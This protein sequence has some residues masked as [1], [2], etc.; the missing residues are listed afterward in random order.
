MFKY[1][2]TL[3]TH[4]RHLNDALAIFSNDPDFM[5]PSKKL[6]RHKTYQTKD[7]LKCEI[8]LPGVSIENVKVSVK[9]NNE[10]LIDASRGQEKFSLSLCP[11][12]TTDVNHATAQLKDGVLT[13]SVPLQGQTLKEIQVTS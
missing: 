8:D 5:V 12:V 1:Y 10:L 3:G 13:L 7:A 4:S 11:D 2:S 6:P 9:N